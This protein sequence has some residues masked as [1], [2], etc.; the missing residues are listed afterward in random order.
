M[1]DQKDQITLLKAAKLLKNKLN[2]EIIIMGRGILRKKLQNFISANELNNIVRLID[3]KQNPYP[4]I[5]NSDLFILTSKFEGLPNVLLEAIVLKKFVI[6][7]N[8]PTGPK[9][10]LDNGKGGML[11]KVG[12]YYNLSKKILYFYNNQKKNFKK[13]QHSTKRLYRFNYN[14]CLASYFNTI[15]SIANKN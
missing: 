12:D 4:Y 11:F 1:V 15:L 8:C 6:S 5:V 7:T 13:R 14:R 10:I 9:E 2:F 3:F